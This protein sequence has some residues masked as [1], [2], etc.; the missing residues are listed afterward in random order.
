[1]AKLST[2]SEN[3]FPSISSATLNDVGATTLY[4]LHNGRNAWHSRWV[5]QYTEGCM[6]SD[7]QSA[8]ASAER[9]RTQGSVFYISEIPALL[10]RCSAG[11]IAVTEINTTQPLAGYSP[12]ALT[13]HPP[14]G[15][16]KIDGFLD[17][18]M[19]KGAPMR[20]LALSFDRGSRFWTKQPSLRNSVI[21]VGADD[22]SVEF[23]ANKS[24]V[25]S[26]ARSYSNGSQYLLGW[27]PV[28]KHDLP[29]AARVHAIAK[30]FAEHTHAEPPRL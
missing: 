22:P 11:V 12:H 4:Y 20:G 14:I 23:N 17:C 9:Q 26:S 7:E 8:K 28:V 27:R 25:F 13:A 21:M 16:K 18:Y 24:G 1:M 2:F 6:H 5:R 29:N 30:H 15:A 19:V 3:R 10:C